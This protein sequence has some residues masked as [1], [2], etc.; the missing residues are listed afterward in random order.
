MV[1]SLGEILSC[2]EN[3]GV[4][5]DAKLGKLFSCMSLTTPYSRY[6]NENSTHWNASEFATPESEK[7]RE[8]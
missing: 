8:L 3:V 7:Y 1:S 5:S 4:S 2:P 6:R